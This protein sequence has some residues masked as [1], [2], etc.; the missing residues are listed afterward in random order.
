M[1]LEFSANLHMYSSFVLRT[2]GKS[3]ASETQQKDSHF[4]FEESVE[5]PGYEEY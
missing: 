1:C 4:A 2:A 3:Q 5:G